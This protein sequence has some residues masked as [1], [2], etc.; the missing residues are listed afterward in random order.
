MGIDGFTNKLEVQKRYF[1]GGWVKV[2]IRL[3]IIGTDDAINRCK[4]CR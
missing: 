3:E 1:S 2:N 4:S